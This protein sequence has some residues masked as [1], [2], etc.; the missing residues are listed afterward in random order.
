MNKYFSFETNDNGFKKL[1]IFKLFGLKISFGKITN[2]I[3]LPKVYL[4][5]AAIM[6]NEGPYIKEWIEYHKIVGV[7]RFYLYDNGSTDETKKVLEPY[8]KDGSVIYCY[9]DKKCMQMPVYANAIKNSR[10]QTRW[11]ALIDLDEFIVPVEKNSIKDFLKDYEDYPA[12]GINWVMYDSSKREKMPD[13]LVT[14]AYTTVH[15]DYNLKINLHIKSIVNPKEVVEDVGNPH[16]FI[17]KHDKLAVNENFETIDRGSAFTKYNSVKKIRINHYYTKSLQEYK[18]KTLRGNADTNNKRVFLNDAVN[19]PDAVE[20]K[21]TF[22]Y[23]PEL[24][25]RMRQQTDYTTV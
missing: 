24:K 11:L 12:V 19:F 13:M 4:S 7:E 1:Y 17:Y 20:D 18:Q 8:I 16:C 23:L 10:N 6:K 14:E 3:K 2:A 21:T 9:T 22:K 15:K 5:I 25:R